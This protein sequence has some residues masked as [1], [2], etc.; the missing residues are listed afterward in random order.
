MMRR[1]MLALGLLPLSLG[2]VLLVGCD[3]DHTICAPA[4]PAARMTGH[5]RTG[6]DSS[7]LTLTAI[8]VDLQDGEMAEYPTVPAEDGAYTL[9]VAPG[10]YVLKLNQSYLRTE[11]LYTA[12]GPGYG[13]LPP[14]TL[15]VETG[16]IYPNLDFDLGTLTVQVTL[17]DSSLDGEYVAAF[18]HRA[19][20]DGENWDT[21]FRWR[22]SS[23]VEGNQ[24]EL[25][26]VGV[27]PGSYQV[28]LVLGYRDCMCYCPWDGE[29]IWLPDESGS[30][31]AAWY[32]VTIGTA[33]QLAYAPGDPPAHLSGHIKGA[34]LELGMDTGPEIS[35]VGTDSLTVMGKRRINADGFFGLVVYRPRPVKLLITQK[36]I[37]QYIGGP[38]F[39]SAT[40]YD[41]VPGQ[42]IDNIETAPCAIT[43]DASISLSS[44]FG[45]PT[46]EIYDPDDL[47]LLGS[48]DNHLYFKSS[49]ILPNLWPGEFLLRVVPEA[50]D[51]GRISW[52]TQ[53]YE[54]ATEPAA[55]T[56][57]TI[58][59]DGEILPLTMTILTGGTISGTILN[60]PDPTEFWYVLAT[61]ADNSTV[62]GNNY[63]GLLGQDYT[64]RGLP[65][66]DY[67]I[68]TYPAFTANDTIWYPG[69]ADW[70][71]AGIIA[72][73]DGE[74][75]W[76]VDIHI[77]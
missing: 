24:A 11:Y 33:N 43:L 10:R 17:P 59:E 30:D 76:G 70:D 72:I 54:G 39:A 19:D 52:I 45:S 29:H 50:Y 57:L 28:E 73:H 27:L 56:R 71:S 49:Y 25:N 47:T 32:E 51:H 20:A 66:G 22:E 16:R 35:I 74:M 3:S 5:V 60:V 61:P 21:N 12:F 15:R 37:A 55:A 53:W 14:D 77:P 23:R 68:G 26:A 46:F 7:S 40:V 75:V 44:S 6:G 48:V 4:V 31:Q 38:D 41:L 65:D 36:G 8:R 58:S 9:D 34:W 42:T 67:K 69:T 1:W 13:S 2:V 18:L 63:T 64:L 62:W